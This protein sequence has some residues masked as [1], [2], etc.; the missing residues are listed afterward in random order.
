M[1][2]KEIFAVKNLLESSP[3][4]ETKWYILFGVLFLVMIMAA[5]AIAAMPKEDK[6]LAQRFYYPSLIL[7]IVGLLALGAN[8][9]SLPWLG[10]RV[11]ILA[12]FAIYIVWMIIG[13]VLTLRALPKVKH[14]RRAEDRYQKY[15]PKSKKS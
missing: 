15:L 13:G 6:R 12:T 4:P 7:G 9:E 1:P 10:T 3:I 8:F 5:V 14:E 11:V 2:F